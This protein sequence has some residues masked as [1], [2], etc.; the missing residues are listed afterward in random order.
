MRRLTIAL[1]MDLPPQHAYHR[2]TL[3]AIA[4]AAATVSG[5]RA[6]VVPT[7]TIGGRSADGLGDGV[8]VGPGSPYREPDAA[9]DVIG[10]A[11]E[12]GVPLVGT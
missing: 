3:A 12:G 2:A 7:D 1:L 8:V 10:S 5:V 6:V 9:L 11:R 4:H